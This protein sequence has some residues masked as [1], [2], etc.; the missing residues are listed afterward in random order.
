VTEFLKLYY[1]REEL[2]TTEKESGNMKHR[3]QAREWQ[4]K[5]LAYWR[6]RDNCW[7]TDKLIY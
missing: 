5:A 6:E 3:P 1:K 7:W 4:T 2:D